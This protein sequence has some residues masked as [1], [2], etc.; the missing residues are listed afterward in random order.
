MPANT[1]GDKFLDVEMF[2]LNR[3][4][5]MVNVKYFVEKK[6][7]CAKV[8]ALKLYKQ[9]GLHAA[10]PLRPVRGGLGG[11]AG[12]CYRFLKA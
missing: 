7:S 6:K 11:F 2:T 12:V 10:R 8:Q 9:P 1:K 5:R 4:K 3:L